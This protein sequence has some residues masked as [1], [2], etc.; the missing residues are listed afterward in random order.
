MFQAQEYLITSEWNLDG[1][2]AEYFTSQEEGVEQA[3]AEHAAEA[4]GGQD[5]PSF[6]PS[7][8]RTLGGGPAP[9]S[10]IPTVSSS[11][12]GASASKPPTNKKFAT[13]KDL[14]S[15]AGHSHAGHKH[16]DDDDD[17]DEQ[18]DL[19]AGGEKSAL[20][21]QNPGDPRKQVKD[22]LNKAKK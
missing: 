2:V 9:P 13:L 11:K 5:E 1:A 3:Q 12:P 18:H 14:S 10:A 6:A 22:I 4:A 21:V 19:F 16:S 15:D 7:G 17:D 8:P 20:A